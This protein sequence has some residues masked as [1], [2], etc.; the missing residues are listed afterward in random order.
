MTTT[1]PPTAD[2]WLDEVKAIIRANLGSRDPEH[3]AA[4]GLL[5]KYEQQCAELTRL[6][7]EN[8]QLTAFVGATDRAMRGV[9]QDGRTEEKT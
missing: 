4:I 6:R 9:E 1:P 2:A 5:G 3:F 7:A 8:E